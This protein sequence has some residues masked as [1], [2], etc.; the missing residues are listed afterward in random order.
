MLQEQRYEGVSMLGIASTLAGVEG[1]WAQCCWFDDP[2]KDWF[3]AEIGPI[4]LIEARKDQRFRGGALSIW[5]VTEVAEYV[6]VNS[7]HDY[8]DE[9]ETV[10]H[11]FSAPRFDAWPRGG[12]QPAWWPVQMSSKWPYEHSVQER[13]SKM[14]ANDPLALAAQNLSISQDPAPVKWRRLGPRGDVPDPSRPATHL[15]QLSPWILA[16]DAGMR[17][18]RAS[19]RSEEDMG[20]AGPSRKK[21]RPARERS[22]RSRG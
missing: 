12:E 10:L 1:L 18:T 5:V 11:Y 22:T 17:K 3:W 20:K 7:H 6:V 13:Y 4:K 9:W 19:T 8:D 14:M 16:P 2:D 15:S 21:F